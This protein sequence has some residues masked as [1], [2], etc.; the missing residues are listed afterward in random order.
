MSFVKLRLLATRAGVSAVAI[1]AVIGA[2]TLPVGFSVI[3]GPAFADQHS[4]PGEGPGDGSGG[5]SGGSGGGHDDGGHDDDGH[6]DD[7]HEGGQGGHN[8]GGHE[9]GDNGGEGQGQGGSAQ[10]GGGEGGMDSR[11]SWAGEGIPEVELGRL[12]VARSPDHVLERAYYEALATLSPEMIAFYNLS[13]DNMLDQLVNNWDG[14]SF[15][16]S[17]LQNLAILEALMSGETS[18]AALGISNDSMTLAAVALGA[19][20]DKNVPI[21]VDTVIALSVIM[22]MDMTPQQV[23]DLAAAAEAVRQAIVEGHG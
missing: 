13:M 23:A 15:I 14:I 19:A 3:A 6:D 5:G 21:S 2:A 18:P 9:A 7:G 8:D 12:N 11:P 1:A 22:D 16:D 4:G 17:P 10:G 20:S